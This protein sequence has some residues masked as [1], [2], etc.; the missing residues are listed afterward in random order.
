M[1]A[2]SK[3]MSPSLA[4]SAGDRFVEDAAPL[5]RPAGGGATGPR[6][7]AART[8]RLCRVRADS[9]VFVLTC[10]IYGGDCLGSKLSLGNAECRPD[11][12]ARF[13][14]S[15]MANLGDE[16]QAARVFGEGGR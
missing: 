4:V 2:S 12:F 14:N 15:E 13:W 1:R 9:P 8:G 5:P 3:L 11:G 16:T 6:T 10:A 7:V